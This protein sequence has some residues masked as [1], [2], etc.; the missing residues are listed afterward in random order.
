VVVCRALV[1]CVDLAT[2]WE[3]RHLVAKLYVCD[4]GSRAIEVTERKAAVAEGVGRMAKDLCQCY[5]LGLA[6]YD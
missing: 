5:N 3:A 4:R 1:I 2:V 6:S